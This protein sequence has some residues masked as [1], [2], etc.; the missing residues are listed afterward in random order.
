MHDTDMKA[1]EEHLSLGL[2]G[3]EE[4]LGEEDF[5]PGAYPPCREETID[6]FGGP[7]EPG[8]HYSRLFSGL[9]KAAG[10]AARVTG[11]T[12]LFLGAAAYIAGPSIEENVKAYRRTMGLLESG[13][14]IEYVRNCPAE[15]AMGNC[16]RSY[17]T[18]LR[19][20]PGVESAFL[21][22]CMEQ[23]E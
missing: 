9:L 6:E 23:Q 16:D 7:V 4:R 17:I 21:V 5:E 15:D 3:L 13:A 2:D 10:H 14:T 12:L 8:Y 22:Y 11:K 19:T 20:F 18:R 1:A